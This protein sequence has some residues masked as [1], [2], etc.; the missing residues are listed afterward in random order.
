M[1]Q[2]FQVLERPNQHL[3]WLIDQKVSTA[4]STIMKICYVFARASWVTK[5]TTKVVGEVGQKAKEKVGMAEDEQR[6]K[7][8]DDYA[9]LH[10]SESPSKP[11]SPQGLIL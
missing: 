3:L 6:R 10:L 7:M 9:K 4:G 5:S 11:S 1:D 2:K 8:V